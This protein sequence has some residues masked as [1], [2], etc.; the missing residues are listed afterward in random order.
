MK[1]MRIM[2]FVWYFVMASNGGSFAPRIYMQFGPYDTEDD[3]KA[4]VAKIVEKGIP[5]LP[6]WES[7][8]VCKCNPTQPSAKR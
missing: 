3:C 7:S 6:C 8:G 2:F 5:T 4:Y 1:W